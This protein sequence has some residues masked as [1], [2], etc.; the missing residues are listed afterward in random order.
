VI[1]SN[2]KPGG[3]SIPVFVVGNKKDLASGYN[4]PHSRQAGDDI[5]RE[6]GGETISVS[7]NSLADFLP[8][9]H[10]FMAFNM[11]FSSLLEPHQS[12]TSRHRHHPP[13]DAY[14]SNHNTKT[15]TPRAPSSNTEEPTSPTIP[16]MDF[17]TFAGS[18]TSSFG[19]SSSSGTVTRSN[20]SYSAAATPPLTSSQPASSPHHNSVRA[21]YERNRSILDQHSKSGF[22]V[23]PK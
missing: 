17:A 10:T 4:Q 19:H 1:L 6:Y 8:S 16:I 7:S 21:Q 15:F 2:L 12:S 14:P 3:A 23:N 11:F 9:S 5:A 18:T 22:P 20:T 13:S